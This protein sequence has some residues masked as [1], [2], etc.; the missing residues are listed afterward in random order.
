MV[1]E[2]FGRKAGDDLLR[3]VGARLRAGGARAGHGGARRR[4]PLRH[5][6]R[7]ASTSRATPPTRSSSA[8][9][10]A[11]A[12]PIV[13]DGVELRVALKAGIAVFPTDGE[14]AE[15][16]CANAETA[17]DQGQGVRPALPVL[18]AGDERAGRRVARHGEPPAPRAR[19]RHARAALPA[20]GRRAHRR[21]RRPGGAD[22]LERPRARRGAAVALRPAAGGDRHDPRRRALGAAQGGG[23]HPPLAAPRPAGAAHLGE[24][25][26]AAAAAEG[27][28]RLGAGGARRLR[29]ARRR[30]ST[31]RSPRACW[32]TTST[33]ARA[34][35]RRCA[36]P[37]SRCRSTTSAP[38]T[39]RSATSRACRSTC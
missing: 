5:R 37:A 1:N 17:L 29:A 22:P 16:L 13:I 30:C 6:G 28:R 9:D 21:A 11:L 7:A 39:A 20:Q 4:R 34:S 19:R 12:Q 10:E 32:S 23:G 31:S 38:A 24:R 35:C 25:L 15:A 2:T 3:E 18:R 36:A 27:L 8:L 14:S 26:G 33:T